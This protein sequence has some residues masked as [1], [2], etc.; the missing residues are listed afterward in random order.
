MEAQCGGTGNIGE[1]RAGDGVRR[2]RQR[3]AALPRRR[4]SA[5]NY[6][7][8]RRHA[9]PARAGRAS[10][11]RRGRS[12]SSGGT[13]EPPER[14]RVRPLGRP[15]QAPGA[16]AGEHARGVHR[17]RARA[18][19]RARW[20]SSTSRLN[21]GR[22]REAA[23]MNRRSCCCPGT[24]SG[25]RSSPRRAA[26]STPWASSSYDER[27]VGGASIDAARRR[28]HGRGARRLPRR[29]R[30]AAGRRRR[31][32]VGHDRPRRARARAGTARAAQGPGPVREPA[33][34]EADRRRCID[35][36]PLRPRA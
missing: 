8:R 24:G 29:R 7:S 10:R 14:A 9:R 6:A 12:G 16:P 22:A 17:R 11:S 1:W 21:V 20:C 19:W 5:W 33:A 30:G 15:L 31:A 28:A 27:L 34:G 23:S 18:R 25:P 13:V 2:G 3:F 4:C 26:C 36:S 35:A 32:E